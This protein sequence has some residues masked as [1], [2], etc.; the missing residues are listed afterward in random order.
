MC[1]WPLNSLSLHQKCL[2]GDICLQPQ[3]L[4]KITKAQISNSILQFIQVLQ[5]ENCK[6]LGSASAK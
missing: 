6:Y 2:R 1:F 3:K 4:L 5:L